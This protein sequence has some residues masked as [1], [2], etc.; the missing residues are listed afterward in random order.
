MLSHA[1][2]IEPDPIREFDLFDQV[3]QSLPAATF[4]P[5]RESVVV[6]ANVQIP[7]SII[8]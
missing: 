4:C 6:S 8:R 5:V 1:E 3:T 7:N 2:H